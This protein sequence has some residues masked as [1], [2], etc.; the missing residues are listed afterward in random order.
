M[1]LLQ[2]LHIRLVSGANCQSTDVQD[3]FEIAV[4]P[5][6]MFHYSTVEDQA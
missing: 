1:M 6:T 4:L 5:E 3:G 2:E